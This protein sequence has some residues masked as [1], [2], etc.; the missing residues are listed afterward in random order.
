MNLIVEK[1]PLLDLHAFVTQFPVGLGKIETPGE[2][3]LLFADP[4]P[5]PSP[6]PVARN[7]EI[8]GWVRDL[9][10]TDGFKPTGRN[11]PAS[12][13]LIKAAADQRLATINLAVDVC[14]IVSLFSGI[15]IS[16][17]DLDK[18]T[19]PLKV[20]IAE[21]NASYVFNPSGQ[22]ID[23]G[24]LL[25]L[26]DSDGPCANAVKD[27]QRTKTDPQ[28]KRVLTLVWGSNRCEPHN[29]AAV[30]WYQQL[31]QQVGGVIQGVAFDA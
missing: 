14:N 18:T 6:I 22:T 27:S 20:A 7:D 31:L 9:L 23:I 19:A 4:N 12:E 10:R 3:Q 5:A 17:V 30:Q 16:V 26:F 15:P 21:K 13:Y 11:K 29:Q 24:G 28:S 8:K 2:Y 1:H 25:C